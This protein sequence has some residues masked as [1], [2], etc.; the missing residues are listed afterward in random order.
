MSERTLKLAHQELMLEEGIEFAT[1][2]KHI[3][4]KI[5]GFNLQKSRWEKNPGL[6]KLFL[7][8]QEL[9]V[10]IADKIQTE[11]IEAGLPDEEEKP[12][13]PP[14]PKEETPEEKAAILAE[15]KKAIAEKIKENAK[16]GIISRVE[17]TEILG[18]HPSEIE[19]FD[20]VK[21]SKLA[22]SKNFAVIVR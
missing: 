7:N 19:V 10:E 8:L 6:E 21:I 15:E 16:K 5:S 20:T 12:E 4:T 2:P 18:R 1:L 3:R 17:L 11:V 13:E 22:F 14:A 9:S